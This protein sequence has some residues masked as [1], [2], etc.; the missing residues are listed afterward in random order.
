M[1]GSSFRRCEEFTRCCRLYPPLDPRA[2]EDS[3]N[4]STISL[5][6][7]F[8]ADSWL[9]V[10]LC[11]VALNANK[12]ELSVPSTGWNIYCEESSSRLLAIFVW[13]ICRL[14][15]LDRALLSCKYLRWSSDWAFSY[16]SRFYSL[17]GNSIWLEWSIAL[18]PDRIFYKS[19]ACNFLCFWEIP[20]SDC[21]CLS[22]FVI[23]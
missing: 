12:L 14:E 5:W 23:S 3:S 10:N 4:C 20:I 6:F 8:D 2:C 7:L 15:R 22:L 18:V 17:R 19:D 16:K 9:I 13:L 1:S 11:C 21:R